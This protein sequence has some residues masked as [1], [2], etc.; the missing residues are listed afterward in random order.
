MLRQKY[1]SKLYCTLPRY[2]L[3]RCFSNDLFLSKKHEAEKGILDL[4]DEDLKRPDA[5][6]FRAK[7][8]FNLVRNTG[9][10]TED[11]VCQSERGKDV[12]PV[13]DKDDQRHVF[14]KIQRRYD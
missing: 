13:V 11:Y 6:Q 12:A 7:E 14:D 2:S 3:V 1:I 10:P 4:K 9:S 8:V 5:L